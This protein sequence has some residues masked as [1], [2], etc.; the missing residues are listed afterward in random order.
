MHVAMAC[1]RTNIGKKV[2]TGLKF[3]ESLMKNRFS[4]YLKDADDLTP[5]GYILIDSV[6]QEAVFPIV[7][8]ATKNG[9]DLLGA[10]F[11]E[12]DFD[13]ANDSKS[14]MMELFAKGKMTLKLFKLV[15]PVLK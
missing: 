9:F 11:R 15:E 1:Y 6:S 2:N 14:F 8:L 4:M 5:L 3:I 10:S 7:Q 13:N 12:E